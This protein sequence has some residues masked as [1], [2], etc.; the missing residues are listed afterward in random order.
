M[1]VLSLALALIKVFSLRYGLKVVLVLTTY[2]M[3]IYMLGQGSFGQS[4]IQM[5]PCFLRIK[6]KLVLNAQKL[7]HNSILTDIT[8]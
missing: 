8:L 4:L 1:L 2:A 3:T 7:M 6:C 5:L